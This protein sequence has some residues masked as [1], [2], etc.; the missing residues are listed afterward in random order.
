MI[1]IVTTYYNRK[2]LFMETL[3]TIKKSKIKNF[4]FIVV[5][6]GSDSSQRLENIQGRFPFLKIIRLEPDSKWYVNPC[7]PFN[8]GIRESN[9]DKIILQN[10]EC[11]HVH[12]ILEYVNNNLNDTN[13][14]TFS[15]YGLDEEANKSIQFHIK[16]K[17]LDYFIKKL[18]QRSIYGEISLGWYNHSKFRPGHYHFCAAITRNN[19]SKLNGF[20]ERFAYGVG[21]DDDE[22]LHRVKSLGLNP[23]IIDEASVIHQHHPSVYW[24]LPNPQ[25]LGNK[26]KELLYMTTFKEN[27]Y[28]AP[29]II[30]L[31]DGN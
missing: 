18:P 27:N 28:H 7:V 3:K 19:M 14:I 23:T 24:N 31:W 8:I 15:A 4:E 20:D 21:Y 26:N 25:H 16:N 6:D 22:F 17:S 11:L 2:N 29:N 12:D 13:Y 10:P 9:G 1:S 30:E 5:D